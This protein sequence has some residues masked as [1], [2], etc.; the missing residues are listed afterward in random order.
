[1]QRYIVLIKDA[2]GNVA[3]LFRFTG[4]MSVLNASKM[5]ERSDFAGYLTWSETLDKWV[6]L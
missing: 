4:S 3:E 2:A 5:Y 6:P 1:M